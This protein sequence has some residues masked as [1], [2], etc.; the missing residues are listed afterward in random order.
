M[1]VSGDCYVLV[2]LGEVP[3]GPKNS[4]EAGDDLG[5]CIPE[6]EPHI[7]SNLIIAAAGGM[8]L[9]SGGNCTC[10][11]LLNVHVNILKC[12]IP[13]KATRTDLL[14]NGIQ[15]VTN[16]DT[17]VVG[18]D[19]DVGEHTGMG[20]AAKNIVWRKPL[21]KGH[22]LTEPYHTV[23]WALG[24]PTTPRCLLFV[25]HKP[26][27]EQRWSSGKSFKRVGAFRTQ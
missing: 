19:A 7:R 20:L 5:S 18:K 23:T 25:F 8:Q 13:I 17:F 1:G 16:G 4:V 9:G 27:Q 21:I 12:G 10:E 24:K 11:G 15:A 14:S 2:C 3:Q 26:M 6:E 22:G